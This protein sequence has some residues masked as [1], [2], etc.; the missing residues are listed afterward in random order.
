MEVLGGNKVI[1]PC[2][3]ILRFWSGTQ[4]FP[5]GPGGNSNESE[6][7]DWEPLLGGLASLLQDLAVTRRGREQ[8]MASSLVLPLSKM[9]MRCCWETAADAVGTLYAMT[10]QHTGGSPAA[11]KEQLKKGC[12]TSSVAEELVC[13]VVSAAQGAVDHSQPPPSVAVRMAADARQQGARC[14]VCLLEI[15]TNCP[16]TAQT[17]GEVGAAAA[18]VACLLH[19]IKWLPARLDSDNANMQRVEAMHPRL[20]YKTLGRVGCPLSASISILSSLA[21]LPSGDRWLVEAGAMAVLKMVLASNMRS[22]ECSKALE[23]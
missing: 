14:A 22:E 17:V 2:A 3:A 19:E 7:L 12:C 13:Y 11:F 9:L 10:L 21:K 4:A 6:M 16:G 23:V 18:A 20:V 1:S 15:L 5:G 8:V